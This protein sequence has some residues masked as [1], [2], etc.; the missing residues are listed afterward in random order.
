MKK[1]SVD[2]VSLPRGS[3]ADAR[4]MRSQ[5][6]GIYDALLFLSLGFLLTGIVFLFLELARYEFMITP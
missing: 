5:Q 6:P 1:K 4:V 2:D 3:K